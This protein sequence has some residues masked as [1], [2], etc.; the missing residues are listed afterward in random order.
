MA[1]RST[2]RE[3]EQGRQPAPP[4]PPTGPGSRQF[5]VGAL[6]AACLLVPLGIVAVV[7]AAGGGS[8]S[9]TPVTADGS[10]TPAP[11]EQSEQ[12]RLQEATQT[13]DKN[14]VSD[15]TAL[16]RSYAEE[17]EPV[18]AGVDKTLP[19]AEEDEIGPLASR[20]EVAG[21]VRTSRKAAAFFDETVSGDTGANVAR[22]ALATAVR[23]LARVAETYQLALQRPAVRRELLESARAQRD[24][25]IEAWRTA[26]I[27]IDAINIAVGLG[28]QHPPTPGTGSGAP[29][30]DLPEG[31]AAEDGG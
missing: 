28:H 21:W 12:E 7:L 27:Q 4:P 31:T 6:V 3:R 22:G 8:E 11:T 16:M 9:P 10:P 24:D 20:G 25:A 14:Q 19:P 5:W 17:L 29:P 23:G 1:K 15:L 18:V 26:G 2:R 30:D 13:R